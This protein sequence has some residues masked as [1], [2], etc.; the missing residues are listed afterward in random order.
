MS[1]N[2]KRFWGIHMG[3]QVGSRPVDNGYVAIGWPQLGDLSRYSGNRER[4]KDALTRQIQNMKA[5][6]VPVNAGVLVRFANEMT[7]GDMVVYPSKTDRMVNIG[8]IVGDYQYYHDDPHDYP[9]HRPVEWLAHLPRNEFSQSA[10]YE[11][12]SFISLFRIRNHARDFLKKADPSHTVENVEGSENDEPDDEAVTGA[13]SELAV[14]VADDYIIR[15]I[16]EGLSGYDFE[17]FVAHLLEQI[18]Y[19]CRVTSKSG[20]GGVDVI[21]HKDVLGFEPPILKVQCKKITSKTGDPEVNQLLGTIGEGE[22]ALFVTLGSYSSKAQ[23]L[24]RNRPKLRLIDGE[25]L[26]KLVKQNYDN[27]SP[28][29]E[30]SCASSRFMSPTLLLT[31]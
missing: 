20:D 27:L 4:I 2:D 15:Q 16:F 14:E 7:I 28:D 18:G 6:A 17:H 10:L 25:Q 24:E 1:S 26:V 30:P 31:E 21:A 22:C 11:I 23:Q 9:N 3:A 8:R 5:G 13:I 29:I 12:G 19:T